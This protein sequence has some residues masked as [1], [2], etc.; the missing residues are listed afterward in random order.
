MGNGALATGPKLPRPSSTLPPAQRGAPSRG[1]STARGGG[2]NE[3][4]AAAG[5]QCIRGRLGHSPEPFAGASRR[6]WAQV[7]DCPRNTPSQACAPS[8]LSLQTLEAQACEEI[9]VGEMVSGE[10]V[11]FGSEHV[12]SDGTPASAHGKAAT[13]LSHDLTISPLGW[14]PALRWARRA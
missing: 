2:R 12:L 9:C 13:S 7:P 11:R 14:M 1:V 5:T 6:C 10:M 3:G 4:P 8:S